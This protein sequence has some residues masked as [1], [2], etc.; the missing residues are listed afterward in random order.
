MFRGACF[1]YLL[2]VS[3]AVAQ[4]PDKDARAI[5]HCGYLTFVAADQLHQRG[6]DQSRVD[7]MVDDLVD[8]SSIF[9]ALTAHS[10][11]DQPTDITQE[12]VVKMTTLGQDIHDDRIRS[13]SSPNALRLTNALLKDCRL[14]LRLLETK[15]RVK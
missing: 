7:A 3:A 11:L 6:A 15:L 13:M 14:D 9:G 12:L 8:L 4:T 5:A 1:A 2:C 10:D